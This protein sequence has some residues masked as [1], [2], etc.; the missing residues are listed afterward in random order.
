MNKWEEVKRSGNPA[1]RTAG[2]V[3]P[4]DLLRS[5]GVLWDWCIGEIIMKAYRNRAQVEKQAVKVLEDLDEIIH[6]ATMLKAAIS[7]AIEG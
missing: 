6:H 7:K 2:G 5:G 3:E 1:Y 4:I